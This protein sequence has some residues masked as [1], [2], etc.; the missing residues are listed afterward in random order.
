MTSV[1]KLKRSHATGNTPSTLN[2]GEMAV[3]TTDKKI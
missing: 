2:D 3:N 1:I